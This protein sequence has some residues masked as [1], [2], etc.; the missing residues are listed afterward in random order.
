MAEREGF[1]SNRPVEDEKVKAQLQSNN[2]TKAVP[3][4]PEAPRQIVIINEDLTS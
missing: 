1:E 3:L 2:E 4:D